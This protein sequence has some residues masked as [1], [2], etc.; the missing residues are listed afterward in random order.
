ML[1]LTCQRDWGLTCTAEGTEKPFMKPDP[2]SL[3]ESR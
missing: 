2:I 1:V 3:R